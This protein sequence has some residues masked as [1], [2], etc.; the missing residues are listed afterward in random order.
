MKSK[1]TD[2]PAMVLVGQ[3]TDNDKILSRAEETYSNYCQQGDK[4]S[5][6]VLDAS[7]DEL[8]VMDAAGDVEWNDMGISMI[9]L[10]DKFMPTEVSL[11]NAY[12]NPFNPSTMLSYD[13]PADMNVSLSIYD[14]RGRMVSELVNDMREQGS[15]NVTWN[16]DQNASGIYM[17]KLIAG[18]TVQTQ[19]IMLVK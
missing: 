7:T 17:I 8:L 15:Y 16:A 1:L 9:T 18:S 6:K 13:V 4:I 19:K 14:M 3:I 2:V 12:P 5:F 11:G 10:V